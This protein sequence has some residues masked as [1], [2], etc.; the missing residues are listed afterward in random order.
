MLA[1][2]CSTPPGRGHGL[3]ALAQEHLGHKMISYSEVTGSGKNRELFPGGDRG[4]LALR[5][6]GCRCHLA[7]AA[8]VRAAA[9]GRGAGQACSDHRDAAGTDSGRDGEPRRAA[10]YPASGRSLDETSPPGWQNWRGAS[11]SW[12]AAPSTS[13]H[14]S[15]W[16]RC[17]SSAWDCRAARRPRARPAGP[18]TTRC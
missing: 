3:D 14:P 10:G 12:P 4:R 13:T 11:S 17:S 1:S 5:L 9:D 6:R 7:A 2:Y 16:A 8:E 18:R 15:R